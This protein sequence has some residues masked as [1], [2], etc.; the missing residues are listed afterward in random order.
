MLNDYVL[1]VTPRDNNFRPPSEDISRIL[2]RR[3]QKMFEQS[4]NQ[5][6]LEELDIDAVLANAE[7]HETD[8][9]EGMTADGGAE[10]LKSFE[11]MDVKVD[12]PEWDEIIPKDYLEKWDG[13]DRADQAAV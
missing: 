11:Y 3:G 1:F 10:F 4:S 12:L 7:E 2:K 8:Q 13:F 9:P 5:K 6:K